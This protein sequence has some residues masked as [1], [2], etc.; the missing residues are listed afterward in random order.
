MVA[1]NQTGF[2]QSEQSANPV[3]SGFTQQATTQANI[4]SPQ[5][6]AAPTAYAA[7]TTYAAPSFVSPPSLAPTGAGLPRKSTSYDVGP[8]GSGGSDLQVGER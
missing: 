6:F 2:V 5:T 1:H 4:P 7:P 3:N 8:S